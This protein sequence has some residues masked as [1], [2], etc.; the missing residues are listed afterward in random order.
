MEWPCNHNTLA[1]Q[2]AVARSPP[3]S[4]AAREGAAQEEAL[5]GPPVSYE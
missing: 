2:Q 4:A 3:V 1:A 5:G